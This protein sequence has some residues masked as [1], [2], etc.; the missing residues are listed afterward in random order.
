MIVH[1]ADNSNGD[2]TNDNGNGYNS[3]NNDDLVMLIKIA[4]DLSY[5]VPGAQ[6]F[7]PVAHVSY[8]QSCG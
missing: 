6:Q 2:S 4:W 3:S 7:G 5:T 1:K 8:S